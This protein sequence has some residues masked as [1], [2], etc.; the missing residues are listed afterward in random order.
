LCS[1]A[2]MQCRC[3]WRIGWVWRGDD[4][5]PVADALHWMGVSWE[6]MAGGL[7]CRCHRFVMVHASGGGGDKLWTFLLQ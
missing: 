5:T 1:H 7:Q 3:S 2:E 4:Y 6:V